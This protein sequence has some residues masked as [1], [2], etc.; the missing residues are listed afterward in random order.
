MCV[1]FF[2]HKNGDLDKSLGPAVFYLMDSQEQA[3]CLAHP[4]LSRVEQVFLKKIPFD[5][6]LTHWAFK[7]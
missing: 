3:F 6:F 7:V 2:E 1:F 4:F 5:I